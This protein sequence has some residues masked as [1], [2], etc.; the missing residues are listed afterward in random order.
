[1]KLLIDNL[2]H[3]QEQLS[4]SFPVIWC[5]TV[6]GLCLKLGV[7]FLICTF[8][9]PWGLTA[10]HFSLGS[11][12]M[13]ALYHTSICFCQHNT[14]CSSQT[15]PFWFPT[16]L[17]LTAD[18]IMSTHFWTLKDETG[19][20]DNS[21]FQLYFAELTLMNQT[22][23]SNPSF[24]CWQRHGKASSYAYTVVGKLTSPPLKWGINYQ[25]SKILP[26]GHFVILLTAAGWRPP[27]VKWDIMKV[28]AVKS[29]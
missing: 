15:S 26:G 20:H 14:S 24:V 1:M 3:K 5:W 23:S 7:W 2:Q 8:S 21:W 9:F 13:H 27:P 29:V 6:L 10:S 11:L 22:K 28:C 19:N 16:K 12:N 25:T 17:L 18:A 4:W